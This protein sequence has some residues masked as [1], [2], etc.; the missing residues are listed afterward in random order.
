[1]MSI[2][3]AAV[4]NA[5]IFAD[6]LLRVRFFASEKWFFNSFNV[7]VTGFARLLALGPGD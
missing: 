1:M 7:E 2:Q 3:A 5:Q 6:K 4:E